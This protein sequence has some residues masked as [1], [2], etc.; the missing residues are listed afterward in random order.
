MDHIRLIITLGALVVLTTGS[1]RLFAAPEEGV[2]IAIVYDTSGSMREQVRD[3]NGKLA[4]KYVIA[5]RAL[6]GISKRIESFAARPAAGGPRKI[7]AG[8]FVF[9]GTGAK[10]AVAFGPFDAAAL[11]NWARKFSAPQGGTPLG[12]A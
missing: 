11:Q 6:E 10:S 12:N 8:L 2:A 7:Q 9:D 1:N 3:V 5:N 4:P